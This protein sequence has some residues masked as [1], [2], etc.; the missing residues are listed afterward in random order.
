MEIH[1]VQSGFFKLDGGAMFGIVP[2]RLWQGLTTPDENN[3]CTWAMRCLLIETEDRNI[4]VDTG[5]GHKQDEKFRKH[6]EPH[7]EYTLLGSLKEKGLL[8]E[9]ITD[10]FLTHLHFD[11][12][13][14]AVSIDPDSGKLVPTFPNARYWSNEVHYNWAMNPNSREKASFLQENFVPLQEAGCLHFLEVSDQLVEW[15]PGIKVQYVYGHT[16]AMMLLHIET[17]GVSFVYCADLI[18]S[19][20][21]VGLPYIMSYDV[22][23][24]ETLKEKTDLLEQAAEKGWH[25]IFE[26]DPVTECATVKKDKRGRFAIDKRIPLAD[27]PAA[28]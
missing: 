28:W 1:S 20:F 2:K 13:G 11:H 18:P 4:L 17:E 7:G 21:H 23:P 19:S 12:V 25:L 15:I 3:L 8:A 10:V 5:I 16:E 22:R 9:D 6:F 14:G 24:L 27:I 26:H